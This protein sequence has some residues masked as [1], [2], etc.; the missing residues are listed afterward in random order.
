M[1]EEEEEE[2]EVK[3]KEERPPSSRI[4]FDWMDEFR[5]TQLK[6]DS[7]FVIV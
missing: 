2:E 7:D 3:L 5:E 1:T 4:Q 6:Q